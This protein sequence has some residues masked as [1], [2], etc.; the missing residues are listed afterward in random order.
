MDLELRDRVAIVTGGSR[1]IGKAIALELAREGARVAVVARTAA[2]LE[3]AAQELAE[4]TGARV[5]PVSADTADDAS[6]KA[7]VEQVVEMLGP[8]TILVNSGSAVGT[9]VAFRL[10]DLPIEAFNAELNVKVLGYLRCIQHAAPHMMAAG[11]VRIINIS[12]M[13]ARRAASIIGS[14]RNVAV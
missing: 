3:A 10:A 8:P 7:M 9:S 5:V 4:Q 2:P 14:S 11:W 1:G 6:V 13:N 12:G